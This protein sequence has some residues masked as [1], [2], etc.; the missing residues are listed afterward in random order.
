MNTTEVWLD[1]KGYE[2]YY[3]ISNLGRVR[4]LD[5]E[6]KVSD[7]R[8]RQPRRVVRRGRI[9]KHTRSGSDRQLV[10]LQREGIATNVAIHRLVA[11]HFIPN[12]ENLPVVN[13]INHDHHDNRST[14]LEWCTQSHNIQHAIDA[15]RMPHVFTNRH[16]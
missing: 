8:Y 11:L 13:H 12:P 4:S 15:G 14:N 6:I 7:T 3:Q 10:F 5:R 9:L 16:N 2:G 1:I